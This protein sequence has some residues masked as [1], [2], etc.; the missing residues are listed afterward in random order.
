MYLAF[1]R[2]PGESY[3]RLSR[4]WLCYSDGFRVL[5]DAPFLL[6]LHKNALAFVLCQI[7]TQSKF[8]CAFVCLLI[9]ESCDGAV[10]F[11]SVV[12]QKSQFALERQNGLHA[13]VWNEDGSVLD[14]RV[15]KSL[16][17]TEEFFA[18]MY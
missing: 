8:S 9:S 18:S 11:V 17:K 12:N 6:I 1:T 16:T 5:T 13:I 4:Y 15:F 3:C 10:S 7:W 14:Y 2:T